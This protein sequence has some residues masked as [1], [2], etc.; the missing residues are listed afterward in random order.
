MTLRYQ[1][2]LLICACG[3]NLEDERPAGQIELGTDLPS[4][5]T[6]GSAPNYSGSNEI[7][8]E[9]A[10]LHPTVVAFQQNVVARTCGPTNGVCHNQKEYP[11]LHTPQNFLAAVNSPCNVQPGDWS[12]V[13]DGCELPG[14]R[15]RLGDEATEIEIGFIN[16]IPG[17]N[18]E[19]SDDNPPGA[20]SP[21]MHISLAQPV[22][23]PNGR[24]NTYTTA[25]ISHRYVGD[26]DQTIGA[27]DIANYRGRFW[28]LDDGR[29]LFLQVA[30]WQVNAAQA[31][32]DAQ[33]EQGDMNRNGVFGAR[34]GEPLSLLSPGNPEGSYLIGRLRGELEDTL[35]PGTRMPLANQPLGLADMLALY[36]LVEGLPSEGT[37]DYDPR[38]PIN[39]ED[40]SYSANPEGLNLLGQGVTWLGRVKPLLQATCGGCHGGPSPQAGFDLVSEGSYERLLLASGEMPDMPLVTPEQPEN[41]YLWLK[42]T[43]AES[44][45]GSTMPLDSQGQSRPLAGGVLADIETWIVNGAR[46]E[47]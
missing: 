46:A 2:L 29:T 37:D 25:V 6:S 21:G 35:I 19:Y 16:W 43:G 4:V 27:L 41:S 42:L 20:S 45:V 30:N 14:D 39:Y 7:V 33:V 10:E 13:Y 15:I 47:E 9:A 28:Y 11:D 26:E 12:T 31:L 18:Q 23:V 34:Q 17:E 36:C 24:T 8:L 32:I 1:W 40:C 5:L 22:E 3:S 38:S 44:I